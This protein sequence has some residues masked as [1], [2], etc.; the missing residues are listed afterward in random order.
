MAKKKILLSEHDYILIKEWSNKNAKIISEVYCTKTDKTKYWWVCDKGQN[1]EYQTTIAN[2]I[3]GAGCN[4]CS[5]RVV[6]KGFNDISTTHPKIAKYYA[7]EH[8]EEPIEEVSFGMNK[9]F[10]WIC[11]KEGHIF[12][13]TETS[14]NK[15]KPLQL[16]D[17][18]T[19]EGVEYL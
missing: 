4:I 12:P 10:N 15:G 8:N 14:F 2:R 17:A 13:S 11:P 7:H 6:L 9:E 16:Q 1:H 5:G 18:V 3:A 19:V